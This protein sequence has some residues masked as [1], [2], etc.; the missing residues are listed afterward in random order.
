MRMTRILKVAVSNLIPVSWEVCW[1]FHTE[2]IP[3]EIEVGQ[4]TAT[5]YIY[6][7]TLE[8]VFSVCT[9]SFNTKNSAFCQHSVF[10]VFLYIWL[11]VLL[12]CTKNQWSFE[13]SAAVA[14]WLVIILRISE[15][16]ASISFCE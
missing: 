12:A 8:Q 10:R 15:I 5:V 14:K 16:S 1:I 7:T 3:I 9:A 11:Y 2:D 4:R 6:G 13:S